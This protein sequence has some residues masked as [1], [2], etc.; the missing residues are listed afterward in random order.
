MF[1]LCMST[2]LCAYAC[3]WCACVWCV[4]CVCVC[5]LCMYSLSTS[6]HQIVHISVCPSVSMYLRLSACSWL[7]SFPSI[8]SSIYLS[9]YL[10]IFLCICLFVVTG[11]SKE[12]VLVLLQF[13]P[14][15]SPLT[16]LS[17]HTLLSLSKVYIEAL[18]TMH[19]NTISALELPSSTITVIE[20]L[21]N[22][23]S[24]LLE[25]V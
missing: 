21:L 23:L 15:L 17:P 12:L 20:E 18:R 2:S 6:L 22:D 10:S 1:G 13:N 19:L 25:G 4:V 24:K 7:C 5:S 14:S 8:C 3:M 11:L 16:P 9:T